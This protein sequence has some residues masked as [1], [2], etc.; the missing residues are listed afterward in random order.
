MTASRDEAET[1][2]LR[3]LAFIAEDEERIGRFL[4]LTGIGPQ[5]LRE[6]A[7]DPGFLAGV[8]DYLVGDEPL[9]LAFTDQ[10]AIEPAS[11]VSGRQRL[12]GSVES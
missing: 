4:A 12:S 10:A 9:L 7:S 5:D 3:A 8:L 6:R 11:V 2:A 1:I